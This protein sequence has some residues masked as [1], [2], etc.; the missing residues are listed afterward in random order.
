MDKGLVAELEGLLRKGSFILD[1][2][3]EPML[4]CE[5]F[6]LPFMRLGTT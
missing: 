2:E 6:P 5:L 4:A 3:A 1:D